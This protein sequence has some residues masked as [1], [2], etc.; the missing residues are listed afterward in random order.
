MTSTISTSYTRVTRRFNTSPQHVFDA[1]LNPQ[2][3]RKWLLTSP[4]GERPLGERKHIE[5]DA[6]V[7]GVW[8]ITD[9]HNGADVT[10]GGEFLE[11]IRPHRLV[12][13]CAMPKIAPGI[14]RISIEI[15]PD[16]GGAILT[17]NQTGMLSDRISTTE[18]NW[19]EM[20]DRLEV[21]LT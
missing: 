8:T 2:V 20:F 5:I 11:I 6:H 19:H 9:Q 15:T 17:L 3:A 1:W 21:L 4:S 14:N 12:F 7:G 16:K 18:L 10:A 13:T